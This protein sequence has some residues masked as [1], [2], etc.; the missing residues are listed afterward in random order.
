MNCPHCGKEVK[1][2]DATFCPYCAR[3]LHHIDKTQ[4]RTGISLAAGILTITTA[5]QVWIYVL[6][7]VGGFL[8]YSNV[9][10]ISVI[11]LIVGLTCGTLTLL[12]KHFGAAIMGASAVFVSS[13][14]ILIRHAYSLNDGFAFVALVIFSPMI[15]LSTLSVI[16][17]AKSKSEFT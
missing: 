14:V 9:L 6:S 4:K 15:I 7:G 8:G 11:M 2:E 1:T 5:W 13:L 17:T 16:L 3:P 12:R 10:A